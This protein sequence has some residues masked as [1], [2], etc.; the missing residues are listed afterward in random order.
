MGRSRYKISEE[1]N[2]YFTT[3]SAM[4]WLPLFSVGKIAEIILNSLQ[5]MHNNKRIILHAYVIME[6]HIHT[7]STSK[8]FADEIRNFKSY[9]ARQIV[10]YLA[11]NGPVTLLDQLKFYKKKHKTNQKYQVWQEGYH[12]KAILSENVLK[13][14]IEYV[15]YNPVR[16]GF[17]DKPEHWRYSS[18]RN[19]LGVEGIVSIEPIL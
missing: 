15:H 2:T 6:T 13:Q 19:Y 5:F 4:N 14:K 10:D 16:R 17:V 11:I 12:P 9:T 3:M 18:A 8:E 1:S 7:V